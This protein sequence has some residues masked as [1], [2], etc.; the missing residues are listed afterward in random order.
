[1]HDNGSLQDETDGDGDGA[2]ALDALE[3]AFNG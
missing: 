2:D 3:A 1:M